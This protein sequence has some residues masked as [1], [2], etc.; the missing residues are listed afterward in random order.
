MLNNTRLALTPGPGLR[1][2]PKLAATQ[3]K[4][5]TIRSLSRLPVHQGE[6]S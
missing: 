1:L 6:T 3:T 2:T 5:D 4:P